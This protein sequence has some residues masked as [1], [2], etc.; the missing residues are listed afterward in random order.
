[1]TLR[2][3][4][5]T[6]PARSSRCLD[7]RSLLVGSL[8]FAGSTGCG[9]ILHPERRGRTGGSIDGLVLVFDLLWLLPGLLPGVV[10]L[11][12]DF[13]S[14]G[15]YGSS[16]TITGP[17]ISE[18]PHPRGTRVTVVLDGEVVATGRVEDDRTARLEWTREVDETS[19]RERAILRIEGAS[20]ALAS[21]PARDVLDARG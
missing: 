16:T 18:L 11:A 1:M 19:L 14:G 20:G 12:V 9:Y 4:H 6:R 15:I 13:T 7:R 21:S 8:A 5:A 17:T 3:P 2:S 10:A